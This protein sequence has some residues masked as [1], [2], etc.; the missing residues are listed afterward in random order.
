MLK[1]PELKRLLDDAQRD[2]CERLECLELM[3]KSHQDEVSIV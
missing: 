1:E 3:L 2:S